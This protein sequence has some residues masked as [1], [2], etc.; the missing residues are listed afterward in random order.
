MTT[1]TMIQRCTRVKVTTNKSEIAPNGV[2]HWLDFT[3]KHGSEVRIYLSTI[4]PEILLSML[5]QLEIAAAEIE[6]ARTTS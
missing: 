6:C 3:D 2:A 4:A 5:E 1:T